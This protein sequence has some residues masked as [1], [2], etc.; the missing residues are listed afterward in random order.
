MMVSGG[1]RPEAEQNN[2]FSVSGTGG[3]GQSG[4]FVA[5]KAAKAA[6][7]RP[8]GFTQGMNTAISQQISEGGNVATTA[9]AANPASKLPSGEGIA[10]ILGA[11]DPLDSEPQEFRPITDGIDGYSG[12]GSEVIP[13]SLNPNN[14]Q[15][16]NVDLIKRYLPDLLNAARIPGA[17]DSYK[18]MINSLMRE[19][20]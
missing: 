15:I 10:Q 5:E 3:N 8:S 20:M 11:I 7:L 2:P 17:P 14:R 6:Q 18:R 4:K 9:N 16:E 13:K 12:R 19:I 1:F